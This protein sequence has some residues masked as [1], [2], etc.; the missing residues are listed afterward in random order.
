MA[1]TQMKHPFIRRSDSLRLCLSE[2]LEMISVS[3][4]L[5]LKNRGE[6]DQRGLL[7]WNL[8]IAVLLSVSLA[9]LILLSCKDLLITYSRQINTNFR[10]SAKV[11]SLFQRTNALN[12]RKIT[13]KRSTVLLPDN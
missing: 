3:I 7:N 13:L 12:T 1:Y 2:L 6:L 10:A 11:T 8:A 5:F 9:F 4:I